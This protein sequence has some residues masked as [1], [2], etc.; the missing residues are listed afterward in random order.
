VRAQGIEEALRNRPALRDFRPPEAWRAAAVK[1]DLPQAPD[2]AAAPAAGSPFSADAIDEAL[3]NKPQPRAFRIPMPR[4]VERPDPALPAVPQIASA[5][6][7][8]APLRPGGI[9]EA[10]KNRPKPRP[11]RLPAPRQMARPA[12]PGLPQAPSLAAAGG[13]NAP[14]KA[15]GMAD[16]LKNR[17]QPKPFQAPVRVAR[18]EPLPPLLQDAPAINAPVGA[19]EINAAIVGL[20]PAPRLD[21]PLPE[22]SRPGE[23]SA[24]PSPNTAAGA[25]EPSSSPMLSV[26]GLTVR[27]GADPRK[28]TAP[29]LMARAAPTSERALLDAARA[30]AP[31]AAISQ[32]DVSALRVSTAPDALLEGREVYSLAVQMPN[33]TSYYGSWM[34]WFAERVPASARSGLQP[35][36]PVRK[37]DPR[38]VPSAVEEK[39]EGTVKLAATIRSDGGVSGIVVVRSLDSRLDFAATEAF[40][41]WQFQPA[42]RDGAPIEVDAIVEVPFRLASPENRFR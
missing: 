7:G 6:G 42:L 2:L 28:E 9:A 12:P 26:S 32:G 39:I 27:D 36:V 25:G 40:S 8:Q 14:I 5:P 18:V 29:V 38:Y 4:Q 11:F 33:I 13:G 41:K 1:P 31:A 30:S 15:D 10:L 35:P 19:G 34:L 23:F 20:R 3:R 17:P 16:A 21:A 22:G 37:V 24:G